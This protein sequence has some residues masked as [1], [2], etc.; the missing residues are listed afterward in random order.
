MMGW[1]I[2][3]FDWLCDI[4]LLYGKEKKEKT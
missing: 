4:I 2:F 1:S 3:L